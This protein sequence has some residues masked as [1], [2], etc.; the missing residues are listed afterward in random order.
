MSNSKSN[1]VARM[2]AAI[3]VAAAGAGC[4]GFA[5][6]TETASHVDQ[7]LYGGHDD[8]DT[9]EANVVVSLEDG[10]CTGTLIS[11][12]MVLTASHCV[13]DAACG[14]TRP[15]INI[16]AYKG[17]VAYAVSTRRSASVATRV[18]GCFDLSKEI[19]IDMAILF[20][21]PAKPVLEEAKIVRP[22]LTSPYAGGSD[23]NGGDYGQIGMA[24]WSPFGPDGETVDTDNL[25][26][27]QAVNYSKV[28]LHHY[29]GLPD[30][31]PGQYWVHVVD[32]IGVGHGDSGGP[33]FV[34]R[35]DG[36]RDPIGV[37]SGISWNLFDCGFYRCNYWAD[38]TR[39]Y[40]AQWI[41][42]QVLDSAHGGHTPL[43]RTRHGRADDFWYGEVDYTGP[44]NPSMDSDCDHW[45]D[46]HDNCP[47]VPNTDQR[48]SDDDGIGDAC[49]NILPPSAP[50]CT[51]RSVCGDAFVDIYADC[52]D[53]GF[54][55]ALQFLNSNGSWTTVA[56]GEVTTY[57]TNYYGL[58]IGPELGHGDTEVYRVCGL[59]VDQKTLGACASPVT[60]VAQSAA[61]CGGG[62]GGNGSGGGG[63]VKPTPCYNIGCYVHR[64]M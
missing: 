39:G 40:N 20:L 41:R 61:E 1:L 47:K 50:S 18:N 5:A 6:P 55:N 51:I 35:P 37:L 33:L 26:H 48:D 11:P 2:A 16:G 45:Y 7:A 52:Q 44:C 8:G 53:S 9:L 34:V 10:E 58:Y 64:E 59:S 27:R 30:D 17:S 63:A 38:I 28:T 13:K 36:T 4:G 23:T 57:V 24:G 60:I 29:P 14:N 3:A 49:A 62:G 32:G 22:S 31:P 54:V 46:Y 43:W 21:D 15:D 56:T 25:L 42:D 19:G 12:L